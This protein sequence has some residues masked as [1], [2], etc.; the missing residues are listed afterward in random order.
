MRLRI[1]LALVRTVVV[2]LTLMVVGGGIG[3]YL[4]RG[5]LKIKAGEGLPQV[6]INTNSPD[7]YEDVDFSLFWEVW[8]KM[9]NEYLDPEKLDRK[10]MVYGAIEGMVSSAGDPYTVFLP[11]S[12]Q[13]RTTEDLSGSFEGVGIQLGYIQEQLAVVAPL[14]GMP[15]EKAGVEAG[16]LIVHIKDEAKGIDTDTSGMSLPEAVS[17]I[18]GEHGLPVTLTLYREGGS[19]NQP[20]EVALT[21]DTIVVPSVELEFVD[22]S[23]GRKVA[24]L[25]LLRFGGRTDMEWNEAVDGILRENA[26]GVVLDMRNNPGGFLNGAIFIA[27]EFIENGVVVQ[28]QGKLQTETFSVNRRGRLTDVPVV[29]LV[30]RGSASASEIVAGALRDRLHAK[31]VGTRT[32]GK[33][34]VQ[35]AEDLRGSTGIHITVARWLLPEG[36]WIHESGL[37]P[38]VEATNSAETEADE[39]L[40]TAI[41]E[42]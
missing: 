25:S 11:P 15:A 14:K 28:Q 21:R 38:D 41:G 33:G 34:T 10:E 4:G 31:L 8:Q 12:D 30:N 18:R 37:T 32:F 3:Y 42:L 39:M 19:G 20:F 40:D 2:A 22:T 1:K 36:D 9:E 5:D 17:I 27:S 29:V 24:H 26:D 23:D 7:E 13:Q 6:L 16:D 35:N